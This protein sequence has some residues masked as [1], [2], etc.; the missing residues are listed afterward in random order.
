M[1]RSHGSLTPWFVAMLALL[2][3]S[4]SATPQKTSAT[5]SD[6]PASVAKASEIVVAGDIAHKD[7]AC[8]ACRATYCTLYDGVV[9]LV[10]KCFSGSDPSFVKQCTDAMNCAYEKKCGST[11]EGA[12]ECFCGS[13]DVPTCLKPGGPNGPCQA[14]WLAAG[15]T[16][17]VKELSER[18]GDLAFPAGIANYFVACDRDN[19]QM[20]RPQAKHG[21]D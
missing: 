19:C 14:E 17:S 2:G 4:S 6:T 3:C 8:R 12:L 20:C 15:R 16:Q 13:A 18:F 11:A 10:D 5:G 7:A 9:N 21:S 1:K